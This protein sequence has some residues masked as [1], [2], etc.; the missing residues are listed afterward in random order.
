MSVETLQRIEEAWSRYTAS[1]FDQSGADDHTP[2]R[3]HVWASGIRRCGRRMALDLLYPGDAW[4]ELDQGGMRRM[5][6]G[7]HIE[8]HYYLPTLFHVGAWS[9]PPFTVIH[10]QKSFAIRDLGKKI[11][12]GRIDGRLEIHGQRP[13][14]EIKSGAAVQNIR[15][16]EDFAK[17]RWTESMPD[18]LL[19]YLYEFSEPWGFF[20]LDTPAGP[21][22][23]YV[24]L[25]EN[26]E[27]VQG[28]LSRSRAAVEAVEGG[29]LPPHIEDSHA[30]GGCPHLGR[31]CAPPLFD[32]GLKVLDD[33]LLERALHARDSHAE[34]H[35]LWSAADKAIKK[36]LRGVDQV[37]CGPF[38]ITGRKTGQG[39]R[40]TVTKLDPEGEG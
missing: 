17:S 15:C 3:G 39:W 7:R 38:Y 34:G 21:R 35:R 10:G 16:F 22:F 40:S 25:E 31:N 1:K 33:P 4:G 20:I 2:P 5:L 19:S 8:E 30:C 18:Q 32:G 11:M 12:T 13:V 28:V 9:D 24:P 23:I 37:M 29:E 14:F 27:R 36:R 26:L 6:R